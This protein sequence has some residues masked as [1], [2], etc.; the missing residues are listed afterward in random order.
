MAGQRRGLARRCPPSCS[1]RR[2]WRRRDSRRRSRPGAVV[3]GPS[4][5]RSAIAI[6]PRSPG[7]APADRWWSRPRPCAVLGVA[8][9]LAAPLPE[10][11]MSSSETTALEHPA[12][13]VHTH[14]RQV[15]H[16]VEEHRGM[17]VGEHEAVAVGPGRFGRVVAECA[18]QSAYATRRQAH[19]G[20]GVAGIRL[21]HRVHG[22]RADRVD[23]ELL[24]SWLGHWNSDVGKRRCRADCLFL[25][26]RR[27][28]H[29]AQVGVGRPGG[30]LRQGFNTI[31]TQALLGFAIPRLPGT[32]AETDVRH[33]CGHPRAA[34]PQREAKYRRSHR[35]GAK[36]AR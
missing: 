7:P 12:L 18:C 5:L 6:P 19:G 11:L 9:R 30:G 28:R 25:A 29:K 14:A 16:R 26:H 2:R 10:C 22:Q 17:A 15:E 21:L 8:G 36:P 24:D 1:R 23:R 20:P 4:Q 35:A 31:V 33:A 3:A 27:V 32:L 34:L 13:V